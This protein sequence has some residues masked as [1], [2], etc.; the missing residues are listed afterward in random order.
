MT[1]EEKPTKGTG[2]TRVAQDAGSF[3]GMGIGLAVTV[4]VC[5]GGGYWLDRRFGTKPLFFLIGAVVGLGAAGWQF[6]RAVGTRE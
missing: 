4:L 6:Y 2:L 5:L 3:L 1:P